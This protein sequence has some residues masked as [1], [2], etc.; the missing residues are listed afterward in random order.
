M[1]ED[2]HLVVFRLDDQRYAVRL[3]VVE[4][5]VRAVAVTPLPHAPAI[6]LGLMDLAGRVLPVVNLRRRFGLPEREIGPA[7][8]FI[9]A[10]T[11]A[12]ALA[13]VVDAAHEVIAYPETAVI[14]AGRIVPGLEHVQGVIA[15]EDGLVLIHAL[16]QCLS[17]DEERDLANALQLEA[18]HAA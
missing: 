10:R 3:D 5:I 12:R 18:A 13:L 6:V 15:L 7:D 11:A 8:Q 1:R 2:I 9:I 16:D 4:R 17:L 14:D